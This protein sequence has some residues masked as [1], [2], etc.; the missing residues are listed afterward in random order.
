MKWPYFDNLSTT[1]KIASYPLDLGK[2]VIKSKDMSS[3]I[4]LGMGRGCNKPLEVVAEYFC[5]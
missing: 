5:L 3:H 2:P 4:A 1:T